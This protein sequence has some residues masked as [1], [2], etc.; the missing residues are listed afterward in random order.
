MSRVNLATARRENQ[1]SSRI[2][3]KS[4]Q[5]TCAIPKCP[6]RQHTNGV[7][8][9]HSR[10]M[11]RLY[12]KFF[13]V[14]MELVEA[15]SIPGVHP[16]KLIQGDNPF[17]NLAA[18]FINDAVASWSDSLEAFDRLESAATDRAWPSELI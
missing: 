18:K 12:S 1:N 5:R 16:A 13:E 15:H 7:C 8:R 2:P 14:G 3:R 17:F 10:E 9:K 4:V 11:G 6:C